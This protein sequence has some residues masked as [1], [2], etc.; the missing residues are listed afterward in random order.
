MILEVRGRW[1]V[2]VTREQMCDEVRRALD[3]LQ[4]QDEDSSGPHT[5]SSVLEVTGGQVHTQV[6]MTR[7]GIS[8]WQR[9][10][11]RQPTLGRVE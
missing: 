1:V 9:L 10:L 4:A 5:G 11:A 3:E 7:E 6:Q 8:L 2:D